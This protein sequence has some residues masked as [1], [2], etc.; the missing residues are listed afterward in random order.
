MDDLSKDMMPSKPISAKMRALLE[1]EKKVVRKRVI[2]RGIIH[3]RADEEFMAALLEAAE[4]LKI[5]PGTLCRNIVWDY[6]KSQH[7]VGG[8]KVTGN[9][10]PSDT[11]TLATELRSWQNE[12]RGEL[13]EIRAHL[14]GTAKK[15]RRN[16]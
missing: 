16:I 2:E 1:K 7:L 5:A 6:L 3:F 10:T 14:A 11:T 8:S 13:R 4:H 9:K 12:I 15:V